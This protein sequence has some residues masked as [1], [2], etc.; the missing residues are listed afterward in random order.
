MTNTN[1]GIIILLRY[2]MNGMNACIQHVGGFSSGKK[3]WK[4]FNILEENDS[5][6]TNRGFFLLLVF[7]LLI[8]SFTSCSLGCSVNNGAFSTKGISS[9]AFITFIPAIPPINNRNPI[10]KYTTTTNTL[11]IIPLLSCRLN[12]FR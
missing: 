3:A 5:S 9:L 11:M 12:M 6:S 2:D 4:C 1:I 10:S 7:F 8:S